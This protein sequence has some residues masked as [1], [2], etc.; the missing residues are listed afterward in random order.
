MT[1]GREEA[2]V[3]AVESLERAAQLRERGIRIA[4]AW[5]K[6]QQDNNFRQMLR[7]LGKAAVNGSH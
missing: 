6:S 2:R 7:Q 4:S 5:R 1:D 3:S